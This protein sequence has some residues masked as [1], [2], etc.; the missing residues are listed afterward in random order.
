MLGLSLACTLRAL[1]PVS[2]DWTLPGY[3]ADLASIALAYVVGFVVPTPGGLGGREFVLQ[4]ALALRFEHAFTMPM[5]Q[6]L[7]LSVIVALVLRLVWTAAEVVIGVPL[8]LWK[9][10][11]PAP[12]P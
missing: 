10:R 9:P 7:G 1:V 4:K 2:L 8:Y 3:L 5:D 11:S 12:Q 6:A